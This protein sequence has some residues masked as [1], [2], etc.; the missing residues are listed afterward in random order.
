MDRFC[1]ILFFLFIFCIS[2][3]Q[4]NLFTKTDLPAPILTHDSNSQISILMDLE[5]FNSIKNINPCDFIVDLPFFNDTSLNLYLES[6]TPYTDDFQL[7]RSTSDGVIY[8]DYQP[9]IKSYRIRDSDGWTGSISF[10]KNYLI[11]VIKKNG[12]VYELKKIDNNTYVL[13]DVNQSLAESNFS[14]QTVTDNVAPVNNTNQNSQMSGGGG[15]ECLEMGIEID[16]YTYSAFNNNCY[17]AV[18]WALALLAGVNEIYMSE[19]NDIV[20]LQ[21]RYINVWEIVDNYNDLDDCGEMLDE[22]PNYWT[23]PPF[24]VFYEQTDLV[25]LF[26]RKQANGG[27]AWLSALCGGASNSNN[28]F[29]VTSGLNTTLTYDYPENSPYSYNLSYLGHEIGHNFGSPHTH[30]CEWDADASIGFPGGAIDSCSDVEGDCDS[31]GAP[32]NQVWQQSLGTIMSYCDLGSV[33]ITLEFHSVVENQALIPGVNNAFCLNTCDDIESSCGNSIYGCTDSIAENY[34]PNANIDDN[35][36]QYIYGCMSP[37]ADN[38]NSNATMDDGSC[39]CSGAITLYI[40]TDYYSNEVG[41]ELLSDDGVVIQ[42]VEIGDYFQGGEII[43]NDYCLAEGC[44]EFNIYDEWGDGISSDNTAGNTPDFYVFLNSGD[45]LVEMV[46]AD[47]GSESLNPFCIVICDADVD[48]DGVCDEDEIYGCTDLNYFEYNS[49]ATEDDGSCITLIVEGCTD[50]D[51][52]NYDANNNFD[53]GSCEYPLEGFDCDENCLSDINNDNICDIFGCMNTDACNYNS[54]AN[55]DNDSCEFPPFNFD[56]NGNCLVEIDCSGECGGNATYD[57]CGLCNGDNTTCLGCVD[58]LACNYDNEAIIDDG[59]CEYPPLNFDCNGNC[60]VEVD[61]SGE[62]GGDAIYDECGECGG[63]GPLE[64]YDCDGNCLSDIDF[65]DVC[66]QL[67]NCIEEFNPD[68][69][70]ND[71]DGYGDECSCQYIDVLGE[72]I[73]EAG[74]YQVYTLSSSID[75]MAAWQIDGGN[76]VWSS[77][78]EPPSIGVQWLEV[79]LGSISITQYFGTNQDCIIQLDVTVIP[80]SIDLSEYVDLDKQIIIATDLLGR[81]INTHAIGTWKIYVYS[82]GSVEKKYELNK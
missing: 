74:T 31:P 73:V 75:N 79:G 37:N 19:L 2:F 56:C 26:S 55:I 3:A 64:F 44:Y 24:N 13:F 82:D 7:L 16:Y 4:S 60:L 77:S 11:G 34:N 9:D 40:E 57:T 14:C 33:G 32:P 43:N 17:D 80:S 70:D 49:D 5:Y 1:Y 53:D 58:I 67:D 52:C 18:E 35:S 65:D 15:P 8:D 59:G 10:M 23:N 20:T 62:C 45:Y 50:D 72:V 69:I 22:M 68:Q 48:A 71:N 12:Q 29:G 78:T 42:S 27:I 30:N 46:D 66:D 38:Y 28:G 25:H 51:A 54:S 41:W 76:I 6:F 21:G 63:D 61:C 36:C 39:I 81:E 47:F